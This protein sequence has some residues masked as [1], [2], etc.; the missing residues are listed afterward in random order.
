MYFLFVDSFWLELRL[1]EGHCGGRLELLLFCLS[2]S[3][4][5]SSLCWVSV[6]PFI[7]YYS[8]CIWG[9]LC[10]TFSYPVYFRKIN[11]KEKVQVNYT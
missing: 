11:V 6:K 8:A 5:F 2:P 10:Y 3:N 9:R 1:L 7:A 4:M